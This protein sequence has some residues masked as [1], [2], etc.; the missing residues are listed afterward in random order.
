MLPDI[1]QRAE[2][3]GMIRRSYDMPEF[4][5]RDADGDD[6]EWFRFDG[7][8]S[9]VDKPYTVRDQWGEFEETVR[10]GAFTKTLKDSKADV[11]LFVNHQH[12][13]AP[14]ATRSG[15][16][17]DL[18]ADPNLRVAARLNKNRPDVQNTRYAVIDGDMRQMSI[19]FSVPKD[20]QTW[21]DD[22]T[23]RVITELK[24]MEVSIV[25]K[26]ANPYTSAA[27][28]SYDD[29]MRSLTDVELDEEEIRRAIDHFT[30]LLPAEVPASQE[31]ANE[32]VERDRADRE[33]LDRLVASLA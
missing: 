14:L 15:G 2:Q 33:R 23:E 30:S 10:A 11:A 1:S 26:G 22:Y 9:V 16:R 4:D 8:A 17:L 28:R 19:G 3:T 12:A 5:F 25:W 18:T 21:N 29:F 6:G 20:R 27:M 24:L 13:A 7:V 31:V 32:F